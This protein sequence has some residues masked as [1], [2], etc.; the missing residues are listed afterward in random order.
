MLCLFVVAA[1]T[2]QHGY[3][4]QLE[5]MRTALGRERQR[6][7]RAE[8]QLLKMR[9]AIDRGAVNGLRPMTF[10]PPAPPITF[11]STKKKCGLPCNGIDLEARRRNNDLRLPLCCPGD[12]LSSE[13]MAEA[14]SAN[15]TLVD[16][17]YPSDVALAYERARMDEAWRPIT[18]GCQ[19]APAGCWCF[20]VTGSPVKALNPHAWNESAAIA[21]LN[22]GDVLTSQGRLSEVENHRDVASQRDENCS[23]LVPIRPKASCLFG[24][25]R[26]GKLLAVIG[27]CRRLGITHIIEEGRYGGLSAL[28]YAIHGFKVT[29]IEMLPID[30]VA[31]S[32]KALAPKGSVRQVTGDGSILV[33]ELVRAAPAGERIAVIF[34]GEK[35]RAAYRTY[36]QIRRLVHLAIFDDAFYEK[37]HK[38][39][40]D[41]KETNWFTNLDGN[42]AKAHGEKVDAKQLEPFETV[43]KKAATKMIR[44][45]PELTKRPDETGKEWK[46]RLKKLVDTE[47]RLTLPPGGLQN[48]AG[49]HFALVR[50]GAWKDGEELW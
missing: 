31:D 3:K 33:P 42:Y 45:S 4:A 36:S 20:H 5:T 12:G 27:A 38:F 30:F 37:F 46:E 9:E 19:L 28:V 44:K 8:E 32:L 25:M 23:C 29:S 49:Y 13:W 50:G 14:T 40:D 47:G 16:Y 41:H 48:M 24:D 39:L 22:P 11:K 15:Q 10:A 21:A 2:G 17:F 35:R 26:P 34:D 7:V 6:R 43:L 1:A 18:I